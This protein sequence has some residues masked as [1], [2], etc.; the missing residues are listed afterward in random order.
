MNPMTRLLVAAALFLATHYVSST[1]LRAR[2]IRGLGTNGYLLLYSAIAFVT[3]AATGI[4]RWSERRARDR[5]LLDQ[6]TGS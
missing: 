2:L 4:F 5:G 1:P 6:T 3:L